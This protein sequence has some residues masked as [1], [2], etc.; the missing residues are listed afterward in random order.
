MINVQIKNLEVKMKIDTGASTN[1]IDEY[2]YNLF[3]PK[4]LLTVKHNPLYSYSSTKPL[5]ILGKFETQIKYKNRKCM[6]E[7]VVAEGNFG[8]LLGYQ[9][10][11]NLGL[12]TIVEELVDDTKH[13][14]NVEF[15]KAKYPEVFSGKIGKLK[16]V[17]LKLHIDASIK[18]IQAKQRHHPIHLQKQI[19]EEIQNLLDQDIIEKVENKP[20]EWLSEIV[21]VKKKDSDA[22]RICTDMKAANRAI[23]RENYQMPTIESIIQKSNGMKYFNKFDLVSAFQQIQ[24]DSECRYISR[25][26]TPKDI[27]QY[28]RLFFGI[29]AASEI[30]HHKISECLEGL[31][32]TQNAIDDILVM[33]KTK[34]ESARNVDL[35]LN[36]LK[37]KGLTVNAAKCKFEQTEVTFFGLKLSADGISLNDQ[38]INA[39]KVIIF[40]NNNLINF[41]KK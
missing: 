30:F 6:D 27:Y 37:E 35:F 28:K 9:T 33:G 12:I 40:I 34:E 36:R 13:T 32:S 29:N 26:R 39:L 7:I 23:K 10:C 3:Q 4:P 25:F 17:K 15:W 8:N 16:D 2:T 24:L 19:E 14:N 18:P 38:K 5:K 20:T 11:K 31:Q 1:V 22:I 41:Q 21:T